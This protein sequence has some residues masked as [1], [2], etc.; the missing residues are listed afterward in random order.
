[1]AMPNNPPQAP[2]RQGP[3]LDP[4]T[5]PTHQSDSPTMEKKHSDYRA[6]DKGY[7]P[8]DPAFQHMAAYEATYVGVK[9]IHTS[10]ATLLAEATTLIHDPEQRARKVQ[11]AANHFLGIDLELNQLADSQGNDEQKIAALKF[12]VSLEKTQCRIANV[13]RGFR[14]QIE[15]TGV[16]LSAQEQSAIEEVLAKRER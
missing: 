13:A 3:N 6:V 15:A 4:V 14:D 1:M 9:N 10:L 7:L 8:G 2:R 5:E 11:E 16:S 12:L